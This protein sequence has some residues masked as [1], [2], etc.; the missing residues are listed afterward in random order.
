MF[1]Y[2]KTLAEFD[3]VQH[4]ISFTGSSYVRLS[5]ASSNIICPGKTNLMLDLVSSKTCLLFFHL[6]CLLVDPMIEQLNYVISRV[7]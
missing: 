2:Y 5:F 7:Q 1:W 6:C 4:Q 3:L